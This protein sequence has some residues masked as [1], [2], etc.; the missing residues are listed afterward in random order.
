MRV[1]CGSG[2]WSRVDGE[3]EEGNRGVGR[4]VAAAG[5]KRPDG[6]KAPARE[7]RGRGLKGELGPR[8]REKELGRGLVC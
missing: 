2:A 4:C 1:G 7:K 8:G 3:R 6:V 5:P